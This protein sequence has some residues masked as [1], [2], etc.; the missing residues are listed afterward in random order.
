MKC[1]IFDTVF[2]YTL[3]YYTLYYYLYVGEYPSRQR[4]F[5]AAIRVLDLPFQSVDNV[6]IRIV[7]E[8]NVFISYYYCF[9][10]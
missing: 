7:Y 10:Q 4:P 5:P 2:Y 3:Y 9:L 6:L 8:S 1:A